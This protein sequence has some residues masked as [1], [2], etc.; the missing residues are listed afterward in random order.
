M[1]LVQIFKSSP[2]N[3]S[4]QVGSRGPTSVVPMPNALASAAP[5]TKQTLR[6]RAARV[7]DYEAS[8]F[9]RANPIMTKA[10]AVAKALEAEPWLYDTY[11]QGV[12]Q[13][14][15]P[16]WPTEPE[17]IEK[18]ESLGDRVFAEVEKLA[19]ERIAK[20]LS[21]TKPQAIADVLRERPELYDEYQAERREL[22]RR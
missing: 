3:P 1:P 2:L 16:E 12:R 11:R 9:Q 18:R 14:E 5:I 13:G 4:H 15:A 10:Q 8:Q 19:T 17:P 6:E 21:K 22:Q 7:I 20:G